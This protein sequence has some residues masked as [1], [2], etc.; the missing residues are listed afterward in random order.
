MSEMIERL[1]EALEGRYRVER[2]LGEG[3]MATVFLAEDI[4]HD[5]Q[6]AIKV[7]KPELAAVIGGERFVTE[8]KTTAGLQH[9][10]ILPLFDSGTS[11][12]FLYYVMPYVE[13]ESLR[14][15]LDREKQLSVDEAVGIAEAVASALHYAHEQGIVHRD[16]K[17]ANILIHAG[18]P[19]VA[20]FGIALAISA[21]GGGRLTETGM[22]V[23]TPHYMSPEQASADR[24][25]SARSDLYAL[26]CVLYE[27]LAGEPPHTGSTAQA[28]LMRILTE[29]PRDV[30]DVRKSVPP[31]VRDALTKAL[32]KLPADRFES[33]DE[34]KR[35][36]ADE[37]F[38]YRPKTRAG[39]APVAAA[40]AGASW[41]RDP[42]TLGL[43]GAVLVLGLALAWSVTRGGGTG[44]TPYVPAHRYAVDDSLRSDIFIDISRAGDVVFP[45]TGEGRQHLRLRRATDLESREVPN[46]DGAVA[47]AFSPDADWVVFSTD[48]G[49]LKKVQLATGT[50][51][52]LVPEGAV[53]GIFT[54]AWGADGTI[55]FVGQE[56]FYRVPEVGGTPEL[57]EKQTQN[58]IFPRV[59]PDGRTIL[60]TEIPNNNPANTRV[61]TQ[62]M[63]TGDTAT[64]ADPAGN[65]FWSPTGHILY[66]HPSATI[67]AVPYDLDQGELTGAPIPVQEGV[68]TV[69]NISFFA[70]SQI[71][72]LVYLGG[73]SAAINPNEI[74][75]AWLSPGGETVEIPLEPTDHP[76]VHLSPDG[77]RMAY[78]R[79]GDIYLFDLDRGT[80]Q[81]FTFEGDNHHD[82]V[83]SP[84]GL[85]I[86][87]T[88]DREGGREGDI[89]AKDVDGRSPAE[90]VAGADGLQ[91]ATQ[92]LEGDTLVL[93]GREQ[94]GSQTDILLATLDS[95]AEPL[96]LLRADWDEGS[97]KVSPDG[98][99]MA[100]ISSET[101][102]P[103]VFVREYPDMAGRWQ[104]SAAPVYGPLAWAP[105]GDALYY[106]DR[107]TNRVIR[108]ELEREPVV[109]VIARTE[110]TDQRVGVIRDV[111][112]DGRILITRPVGATAL[113][114]VEQQLLV[115]ANWFTQLRERLGEEDR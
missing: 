2:E 73:S 77:G 26:A 39:R 89:Y 106:H 15:R 47:P 75:F 108:A 110:V 53:E 109:Q 42:K 107:D 69:G 90:R 37:G 82:P 81:R 98:R 92:W 80:N 7:L 46:S 20:D 27:M 79:N 103:H 96:P 17:P 34:F 13:G 51:V 45:A 8:I 100:Y 93:F 55:L 22:S 105:G 74:A 101:G 66:G 9:P 50:A 91:Y 64:V 114:E 43:L 24:D 25:V 115:V 33:A 99:F 10:H 78:T 18:E 6:V 12:G 52:T 19:V 60:F 49:E 1:N 67:F 84:D 4:K 48:A 30:T 54:P 76:D 68:S 58:P 28:V 87:F 3:G 72:S 56:G 62:D 95:T 32:E 21:A 5:R 104:I 102:D 65:A 11:D 71:G 16:I 86:A 63:E 29:D 94:V 70:L 88:S 41:A 40:S 57:F 85:R 36:L 59:L 23:G 61:M 112:P 31:N 97:P 44:P 83:W 35:A 111:H 14:E 38:R 113:E